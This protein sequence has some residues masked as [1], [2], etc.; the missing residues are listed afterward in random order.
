MTDWL[1]GW[2]RDI[3][4]IILLAT[5]IDLLIP[6]NSLQRY[7]KTVVGLLILLTML[8]PVIALFRAETDILRAA[9]QAAGIGGSGGAGGGIPPLKELLEAGAT[10]KEEADR[11][12]AKLVEAELAAQMRAGLEE[13]FGLAVSDVR[14]RLDPGKNGAAPEIGEVR[15]L[16]GG[17]RPESGQAAEGERG[18]GQGENGRGGIEPV[19]PV[20]IRVRPAAENEG[21]PEAG[22]IPA[23]SGGDGESVRRIAAYMKEAWGVDERRLT[24]ER[25][26]AGR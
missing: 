12:S 26:P 17:E 8:S 20:D 6:N 3:V 5:F 9:A 19:R 16:L 18:G 23:A 11:E 1:G 21:R 2:L 10:L 24:V 13:K 7:V 22:K 4:M 25:S 14:V 15:V